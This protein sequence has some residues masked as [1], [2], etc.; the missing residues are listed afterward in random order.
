MNNRHIQIG[1]AFVGVCLL[2]GVTLAFL[3]LTKRPT[4]IGNDAA[5]M[6]NS[7]DAADNMQAVVPTTE[8]AAEPD[9]LVTDELRRNKQDW[10]DF[11]PGPNGTSFCVG[12]KATFTNGSS[13]PLNLKRV[14]AESDSED[15][16]GT[17]AAGRTLSFNP[18]ETGT[19]NIADADDGGP[20]FQ[21][22]VT[23]CTADGQ[24]KPA[25]AA[26]PAPAGQP[27]ET[28]AEV[29]QGK[30]RLTVAGTKLIDGACVY[31]LQKGGS[32][33]IS[34]TA[35]GSGYFAQLSINDANAEGFWNGERGTSTAR[36]PLG[37]LTRTGPCWENDNSAICLWPS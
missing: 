11:G 10:A 7:F 33:Q 26:D 28:T 34:D 12:Q 25:E 18:G 14:L 8:A 3:T 29:K 6:G 31:V 2:I 13:R 24:P 17:I 22:E 30:C 15:A 23:E 32:F 9:F 1:L 4:P 16:I 37:T 21:Y 19:W 27:Q 20:L 36:E 5:V 35:D